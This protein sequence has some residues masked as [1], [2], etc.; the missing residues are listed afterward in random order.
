M[1]ILDKLIYVYYSSY[2]NISKNGFPGCSDAKIHTEFYD[3]GSTLTKIRWRKVWQSKKVGKKSERTTIR[4]SSLT[5][6]LQYLR[7]GDIRWRY[8]RKFYE[9]ENKNIF[10]KWNLAV[11]RH[12]QAKID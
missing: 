2:Q 10:N 8:D 7:Q 11:I 1:E 12:P 3:C 5:I 9:I 6:Q 4:F